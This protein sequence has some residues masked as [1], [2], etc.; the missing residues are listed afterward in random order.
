M[1]GVANARRCCVDSLA[2]TCRKT[3]SSPCFQAS[4]SLTCGETS[5]W[6]LGSAFRP[7]DDNAAILNDCFAVKNDR[8]GGCLRATALCHH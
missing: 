4:S 2:P 7:I 8:K 6:V 5:R 1:V 3:L